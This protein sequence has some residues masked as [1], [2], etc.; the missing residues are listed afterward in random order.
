MSEAADHSVPGPTADFARLLYKRHYQ[1][2]VVSCLA[3]V[4]LWL[5][6]LAAFLTGIIQANHFIGISWTVLAII[7]IDPPI[8]WLLKKTTK[9][10]VLNFISLLHSLLEAIGYTAVIHFLGGIEA[11]YLTPLYAALITYVGVFAPR[12]IPYIL[13]IF[14]SLAFSLLVA[15]EHYGFLSHHGLIPSFHFPL[16]EQ[17]IICLVLFGLLFTIAYVSSYTSGLLKKNRM[18]L[19]AQNEALLE[20]TEALI[21]KERSLEEA[22]TE[23]ERRVEERTVELQEANERLWVEV[24]ERQQAEAVLRESEERYRSHFENIDDVIISLDLDLVFRMVSPSIE[25]ALGYKPEELLEKHL[26]ELPLFTPLY[27]EL[28]AKDIRRILAGESIA[29]TI[30]EFRTKEG[31]TKYG[32]ISGSPLIREEKIVGIICVARDITLRKQVEEAL[33]RSEAFLKQT[34]EISKI[35]GWEYDVLTKKGSWTEEVYR[36]HDVP[37]DYDLNNIEKA[38][39]FYA[40]EDR[41]AIEQ[42]FYKAVEEGEPY[43]LSLRFV[44]AKGIEKWV[45]TTGQAERQ[46]G[47]TIRI[48]GNIMDITER[49]RMEDERLVLSKL[50]S[51]GILAGGIAHDF[52]NLLSAVIGNL[53]LILM[54]IQP[55]EETA[56][57]F[58]EIEKAVWRARDL[59]KQLITFAQGGDPIIRLTTLPGLL[60]EQVRFTLSGSSVD[61]AF[62]FSSDLW[63]VMADGAQLNQVFRNIVLNAREAMPEGGMISVKAANEDLPVSSGL[64]LPSGQYVKI[65]VTD[66]GGGIKEE[67]LPKIFDPYFSTKQRGDQKGMGLGL[68]ISHSII[69]KHGGVITVD[70]RIGQGTTFQVYLPAVIKTWAKDASLQA[71]FPKKGKILIMD[72]EEMIR[73]MIGEILKRLGY[74]AVMTQNGHEA[75]ETYRQ[76]ERTGQ[77][78]EA[79]I[80]DLTVK[81]GMGGME[82]LQELLKIDPTVKAIVCSGYDNNPIMDH[83][84][85]YGFKGALIKPFQ[86]SDLKKTLF[87]IIQ[88]A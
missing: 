39:A 38:I 62:S 65:S 54:E 74:E 1:A 24:T 87:R 71:T 51:T 9:I 29:S 77:P 66:Q 83:Y 84:Q 48:F 52:N 34:Q 81:G 15:A 17:L 32:E 72:D 35:G 70:T 64:P 12:G 55:D 36:L 60:E 61:Y 27:S 40:P 79:V 23:L 82:T 76:E 2:S 58:E 80:L 31:I 44:S 59:T 47:K 18:K 86:V 37:L 88:S 85:Q 13:A 56:R 10:A 28:A 78:F 67:V 73:R 25:K 45:R 68:T 8:L 75:V 30:Y 7:L 26:Y 41:L 22:Y 42:A 43:D 63:P 16:R 4:A 33:R 5:I 11:T 53:Q 49:K 46:S 50:E 20:K 57:S 14:S 6:A 69:K 19:V 21:E 3:T